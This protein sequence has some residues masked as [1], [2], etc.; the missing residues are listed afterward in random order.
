MTRN[1]MNDN[2]A[3]SAHNLNGEEDFLFFLKANYN[4]AKEQYA[5]EQ[6]ATEQYATK[7]ELDDLPMMPNVND[8]ICGRG[9]GFYTHEG[10]FRF[11]E[12]IAIHKKKYQ[13]SLK[14]EKTGISKS[15]VKL[16]KSNNPPGRFIE[17][18]ELS[19]TWTEVDVKRAWEKTGQAL[20]E[21]RNLVKPSYK[22]IKR[23]KKYAV[24]VAVLADGDKDSQR[25]SNT[26]VHRNGQK[27]TNSTVEADVPGVDIIS[28]AYPFN[29][30]QSDI[31]QSN[32]NAFINN[33]HIPGATN[34]FLSKYVQTVV[35]DN[36]IIADQI[37]TDTD[38]TNNTNTDQTAPES[39]VHINNI[40]ANQITTDTDHTNNTN[41]DQTATESVVHINNIIDDQIT[42]DT[43]YTNNTN[44][45]KTA[46]ESV[47]HINNIIA[48]QITTDRITSLFPPPPHLT[49]ILSRKTNKKH[50]P[51]NQLSLKGEN[52]ICSTHTIPPQS[53]TNVMET[54]NHSIASNSSQYSVENNNE[55]IIHD[56]DIQPNHCISNSTTVPNLCISNS[57]TVPHPQQSPPPP[58]SQIYK[59]KK[60]YEYEH[61]SLVISASQCHQQTLD[62]VESINEDSQFYNEL[63][64]LLKHSN[65][66]ATEAIPPSISNN[67]IPDAAP[68]SILQQTSY[69]APSSSSLTPSL[70][71]EPEKQ[72]V[73]LSN[74]EFEINSN[75]CSNMQMNLNLTS[76]QNHLFQAKE[77]KTIVSKARR[78]ISLPSIPKMKFA[79]SFE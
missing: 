65:V 61:P 1:D 30:L 21:R 10:N 3:E 60:L 79:I 69:Y 57:T 73:T 9:K 31:A 55:I 25:I 23:N 35:I 48:D 67:T 19:S 58:Q 66:A 40:I 20:R 13:K 22:T 26:N 70:Q 49:S 52:N 72:Q 34:T 8:V 59:P 77:K 28:M 62:R 41:T 74:K 68:S 14:V 11:H 36:N 42:T 15:I 5:T 16:I 7:Q 45:D 43:D 2:T 56:H 39:V 46:P 4:H 12:L 71:R 17:Y 47:A 37:T 6:Y 78:K 64:K 53:Q 24:A 75:S 50:K 33:I 29:T 32:V 76:N 18:D 51:N 54:F 63:R 27:A 44:T 38:H